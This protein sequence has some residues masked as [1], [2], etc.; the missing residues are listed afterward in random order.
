VTAFALPIPS[1]VICHLLGVPPADQEFFP[2]HTRQATDARSTAEEALVA[3]IELRTYLERLVASKELHAD[4]DLLGRFVQRRVVTGELSRDEAVSIA[5]LLLVAGHETS[6]NMIALGALALLC[7]PE[8]AAAARL[9]DSSTAATATEEMLRYLTVAHNGRRRVATEDIELGG[10]Q[11]K[12][13]DGVIALLEGA[14][15]DPAEFADPDQLQLMRERN[16]HVAFGYGVHQ[17]LGQPIARL[18]M[19]VAYPALL[20]RFP[21]LELAVAFDE[22]RFRDHGVVYGLHELP[23]RW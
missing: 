18:E 6:A 5:V 11:I 20:R 2:R 17:C 10:V 23:V 14:N 15:R 12:A 19:Q 13:G 4:D 21:G 7:N 22:V 16:H 1:L 3:D 9:G 8:Q